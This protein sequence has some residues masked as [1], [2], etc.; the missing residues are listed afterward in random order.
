MKWQLTSCL[1]KILILFRVFGL[2]NLDDIYCRS[3]DFCADLKKPTL[4]IIQIFKSTYTL[5][6]LIKYCLGVETFL[7][8]KVLFP[9]K[10]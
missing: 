10:Q 2:K 7:W 5:K 4:V 3:V 9:H 6:I 8:Q 1:D